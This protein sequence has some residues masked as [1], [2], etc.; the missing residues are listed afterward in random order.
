MPKMVIFLV[1]IDESVSSN[2]RENT[3]G[4]RQNAQ[5]PGLIPPFWN[6]LTINLDKTL[7]SEMRW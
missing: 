7:S 6:C 2:H 5:K 1:Q 3:N 4:F